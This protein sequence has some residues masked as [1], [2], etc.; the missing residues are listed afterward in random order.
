MRV[1]FMVSALAALAFVAMPAHA[2][3]QCQGNVQNI[4]A[5]DGGNVW[6]TLTNGGSVDIA[7]NDPNREAALSLATT[8]MISGHQIVI[9]YSTDNVVCTSQGRTDFV[10][11]YL[12]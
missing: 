11:L 9:R 12:I 10:G 8:A 1:V 2:S 6:I 5:G 4:W 3:T 7:P